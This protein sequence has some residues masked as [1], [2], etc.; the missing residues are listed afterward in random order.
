[1]FKFYNNKQKKLMDWTIPTGTI[2]KK[3]RFDSL[4]NQELTH[5]E[6]NK[7]NITQGNIILLRRKMVN[8]L[9]FQLCATLQ[10]VIRELPACHV[11]IHTHHLC[12]PSLSWHCFHTRPQAVGKKNKCKNELV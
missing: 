6:I 3:N 5:F 4:P 2:L 1:M 12:R 10:E 7:V 9:L 8:R 11:Q